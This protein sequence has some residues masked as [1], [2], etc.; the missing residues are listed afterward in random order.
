M[1]E[2]QGPCRGCGDRTAECHA[3]CEKYKDYRKKL[4]EYRVH[5]HRSRMSDII[6]GRPWM[7]KHSKA[8]AEYRAEVLHDRKK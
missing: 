1:K 4:E 5:I 3:T 8:Q 7:N 6:A 2:P